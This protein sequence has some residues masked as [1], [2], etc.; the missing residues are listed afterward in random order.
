[1]QRLVGSDHFSLRNAAPAA[2]DLG[3]GLVNITA[4]RPAQYAIL[5]SI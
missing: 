3:I 4:P 5:D 1:M 2:S